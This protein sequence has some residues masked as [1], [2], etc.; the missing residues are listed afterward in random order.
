MMKKIL[1]FILVLSLALVMSIAVTGC[2]S[3]DNIEPEETMQTTEET[4]TQA[5]TEA[6][7]ESSFEQFKKT[8][9]DY[10]AFMDSYCELVKKYNSD[11]ATFMD[12]YLEMNQ[13]Y[14][15][16]MEE[17]DEIDEDELTDEELQYYLEVMNRING[18]L[19]EVAQ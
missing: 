19:L 9:D 1:M 3:D 11:P 12:E 8:M 18:K 4:T 15:V 16:V 13:K 7:E 10:E 14:L 2:G 17:L 5:T 6:V